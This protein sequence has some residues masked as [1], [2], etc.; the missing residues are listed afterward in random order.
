MGVLNLSPPTTP[1]IGVRGHTRAFRSSRRT[2]RSSGMFTP[3]P[4]NSGHTYDYGGGSGNGSGHRSVSVPPSEHRS[5]A[6]ARPSQSQSRTPNLVRKYKPLPSAASAVTP[7]RTSFQPFQLPTLPSNLFGGRNGSGTV[8]PAQTQTQSPMQARPTTGNPITPPAN[9]N[10]SASSYLSSGFPTPGDTPDLSF[11]DLHY[12]TP[13]SAMSSSSPSAP[14]SSSGDLNCTNLSSSPSDVFYR[15]S[16]K[17]SSDDPWGTLT[18]PHGR[19]Q[20]LDLAQS[21]SLAR[22]HVQQLSSGHS[23]NNGNGHG[24]HNHKPLCIEPASLMHVVSTSSTTSP[25]SARLS[26][27]RARN[28]GQQMLSTLQTTGA[29]AGSG[30]REGSGSGRGHQRGQSAAAALSLAVSPQDLMIRKG[31]GSDNNKRKRASW[32]GGAG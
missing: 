18:H 22:A 6:P 23:H 29:S 27:L 26:G 8:A 4:R 25:G 19:T 30:I 21:L 13:S 10:A 32:D 12:F 15:S 20:A 14:L 28:T 17:S 16:T 11:L 5:P 1:L 24:G 2:G 31:K 7:T 3:G 9:S